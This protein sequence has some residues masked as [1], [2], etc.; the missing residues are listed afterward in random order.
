MV[1]VLVRPAQHGDLNQ[2]TNLMYEYIVDFY[3]RPRPPVENVQSL[4]HMLLFKQQGIQFVA[5]EAGNLLGFATLYF[6]FSTT[7][8]EKVT[9]MNDLYVIEAMRGK[10]IAAALF[11]ECHT[12]TKDNSFAY[13]SWVTARDNKRA[14]RFYEKMGGKAEDWVNFSI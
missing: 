10:G 7:R 6:T 1:D 11:E 3:E 4:I 14:Q 13:M 12:F 8:T 9:V 2:L 5:S